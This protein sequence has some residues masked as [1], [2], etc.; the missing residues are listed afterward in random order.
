MK[1]SDREIKIL[2]LLAEGKKQFE[3]AE[4][5]GISKITLDK[6]LFSLKNGL[7]AV[8][9]PNLIYKAFKNGLIK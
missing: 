7:L 5:L 6:E 4:E 2:E 3:I 8:N 9:I 1:F